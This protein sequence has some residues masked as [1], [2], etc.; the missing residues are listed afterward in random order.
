MQLLFFF[1]FNIV[2]DFIQRVHLMTKMGLQCILMQFPKV[3]KERNTV[4]LFNNKKCTSNNYHQLSQHRI[5]I[6]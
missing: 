3:C 2:I 1:F 4:K 5:L 6:K